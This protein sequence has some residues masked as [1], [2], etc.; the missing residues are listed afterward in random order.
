MKPTMSE[1]GVGSLRLAPDSLDAAV[2]QSTSPPEFGS[3]AKIVTD[4]S[5]SGVGSRGWG[6][7]EESWAFIKSYDS[8]T[9]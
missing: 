9:A 7:P 1:P 8:P 2:S 3:P 6:V 5:P 4:A